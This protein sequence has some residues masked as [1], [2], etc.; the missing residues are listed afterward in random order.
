MYSMLIARRALSC[1]ASSVDRPWPFAPRL[2]AA[3]HDSAMFNAFPFRNALERLSNEFVLPSE[4]SNGQLL[5]PSLPSLA[6][7]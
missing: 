7:H 6:Q 3:N 2:E 4:A 5:F 1:L